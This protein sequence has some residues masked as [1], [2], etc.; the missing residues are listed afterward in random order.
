MDMMM[1]T[2]MFKLDKKGEGIE[3]PFKVFYLTSIPF[4]FIACVL[5]IVFARYN[6]ITY[7]VQHSLKEDA[8]YLM[9][10]VL[11]NQTEEYYEM[12]YY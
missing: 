4:L 5:F 11:L 3:N 10:K 1:N 12:K 8:I 2:Y 9:K 7:N 6:T